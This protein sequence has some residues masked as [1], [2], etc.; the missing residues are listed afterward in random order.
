[1]Q[2]GPMTLAEYLT[3][4]LR[5]P[6]GTMVDKAG[7][8]GLAVLLGEIA[9]TVSRISSLVSRGA[10]GE[11]S[12]QHRPLDVA[13]HDLFAAMCERSGR[14][15]AFA[16][17]RMETATSVDGTRGGG[18]LVAFE[19]LDDAAHAGLNVTAGTTFSVLRQPDRQPA[20][21]AAFLRTGREQVAAGYAIYGPST[22]LVLT[23][24]SGVH[25]FTL[26]RETGTFILTH[27]SI[28]L[29]EKATGFSIN[30]AN[31]RLWEPP[32]LRFVRECKAGS[33][34]ERQQDF[35]TRWMGSPVADVHRLMMLGGV[36]LQPRERRQ[37]ARP[38]RLRM[39]HEANPLAFLVDQAGGIASTGRA[40]L[41]ELAP[42]TVHERVPV[43][44]G[45]RGEVERLERYHRE[46][47]S[48]TDAP[49][50]S[51]L[52]NERSLFRPEARA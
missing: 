6:V 9:L 24:G 17:T 11:H 39:L 43:I 31:E 21:D 4:E 44:L 42:Q 5:E 34:G 38:G 32:V 26:E 27:P 19:P 16:S 25:G 45:S 28:R 30:S 36:Y 33:T 20:G 51:P 48:G 29:P 14:V 7:R 12:A 3:R 15:A 46:Y 41:L 23:V 40:R 22:M 47:E 35:S 1:M 37:P 8:A 13:A 10:L 18:Y 2:N 52:F 50:I 49:F